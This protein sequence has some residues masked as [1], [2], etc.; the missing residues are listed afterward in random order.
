MSTRREVGQR[1]VGV[2]PRDLPA[3]FGRIPVGHSKESVLASVPGTPQAQ[4]ALIENSVPQTGA[5][6][7][8]A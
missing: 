4:E 2:I 5:I 8:K 7:L 3:S 1:T 6:S